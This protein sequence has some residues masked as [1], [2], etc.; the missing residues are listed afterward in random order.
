MHRPIWSQFVS[1]LIWLCRW[2]CIISY[3]S[4][5]VLEEIKIDPDELNIFNMIDLA[6][7]RTVHGSVLNRMTKKE[8]IPHVN[9]ISFSPNSSSRFCA[10]GSAL[11]QL[12][13]IRHQI[14]EQQ[15][16]HFRPEFYAFTCHCWLDANSI[17]VSQFVCEQFARKLNQSRVGRNWTWTHLLDSKWIDSFRYQ[18][19][20]INR[21]RFEYF[22]K[23]DSS[24]TLIVIDYQSFW[25]R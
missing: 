17:L 12:Y 18:F 2:K 3:C 4:F 16:V 5:F 13:E 14:V 25:Q 22:H 24:I 9:S 20:W 6:S 8:V 11:F 21:C 1:Y 10:T 19:T 15:T 23:S 7:V